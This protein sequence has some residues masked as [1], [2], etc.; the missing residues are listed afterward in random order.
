MGRVGKRTHACKDFREDMPLDRLE[1]PKR[2]HLATPWSYGQ[3]FLEL[4]RV[5]CDC[6]LWRHVLLFY[7]TYFSYLG[8][9]AY[10]NDVNCVFGFSSS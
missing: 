4:A 7:V 3:G 1:G 6:N 10:N 5:E 9:S 2:I 8:D